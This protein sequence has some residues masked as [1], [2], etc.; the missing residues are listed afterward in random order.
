MSNDK[1]EMKLI[2]I[3]LTKE[4]WRFLKQYAFTKEMSMTD[5][6]TNQLDKFKKKIETKLTYKN[7]DV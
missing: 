5:I 2:S 3:R 1:I 6:V 4:M 7:I